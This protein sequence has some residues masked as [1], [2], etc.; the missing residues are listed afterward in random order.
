MT[1]VIS[2]LSGKGGVGKTFFS[3]NISRALSLLNE[4]VLLID[5]NITTPNVSINL[6]IENDENNL[7]NFLNGNIED[8]L[9]IIK[10]TKYNID[11]IPGSL[12]IKDLINIKLEKLNDLIKKLLDYYTYI[13]I[14]SAA[15]IGYEVLSSIKVAEKAI[16]VTTLDKS[17]LLDAYRIIKIID[18]MQIPIYGIVINRYK[19][20]KGLDNA[21][22]FLNKTIIGTISE[23][24]NVRKSM[25]EGI[26]ILDYNIDSKASQD[27]IKIAEKIT[28]K[29]FEYKKPKK[30]LLERIFKWI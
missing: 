23:D 6:K 13:I 27:I 18:I 12:Y 9:K 20:E 7:H 14:D 28:G 4:K 22:L 3:I 21:E 2:I 16:I 25:N 10:K 11:V 30:G 26:P 19:G 15:G 8:P 24:E 5:A 29:K 1:E 17:A